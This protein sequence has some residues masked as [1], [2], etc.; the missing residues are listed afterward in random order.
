MNDQSTRPAVVS[1]ATDAGHRHWQRIQPSIERRPLAWAGGALLVLVVLFMVFRSPAQPQQGRGAGGRFGGGG[2]QPVATA[3]VENGDIPIIQN[4][5]GTVTPLAMVTVRSQIAGVLTQ[6]A[7]QE[8]QFVHQGDLL[9]LVDPRPYQHALEQA[10]GQLERDQALLKNAQLDATRYKVLFEQDSIAKQQLDTQNAL[11]LQYKGTV[12]TDQGQVNNAKLNLNYCYIKAPISGRVGLRQVD[13]GNYVAVGDT[14]GIAVITQMQPMTAIFTLPEDSVR[15]VLQRLRQG[16]TLTVTAYDRGVKNKLAEGVVTTID[17]QI[18][19]TTG[20]VKLRAQFP[21]LDESL[22]PNQFVNISLLVD[23]VKNT[24]VIPSAAIQRGAPGTFV[25]VV[26]QVDEAAAERARQ[27]QS[28]WRHLLYKVMTMFKSSDGQGGGQG[29]RQGRGGGHGGWAGGGADGAGPTVSIRPIKLGPS[30][31][32]RVAV[33]EGV[34]AG[35]MIVTDGADRLKDGAKI[36]L[37]ND[38]KDDGKGEATKG[39]AESG[40]KI[41]DDGQKAPDGAAS[42]HRS[43]WR[44]RE[45]GDQQYGEHPHRRRQSGDGEATPSAPPSGGSG[46][47]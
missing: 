11:V 24:T 8:G 28:W 41:G 15:P 31:G 40:E 1:R 45:T 16:N 39:G 20:T 42:D 22:F 26:N 27:N 46:P 29:R 14:N 33:Q 23:T 13:P 10:Q 21:N 35:E 32:E 4:A 7:F 5:L 19:T 9:A 44:D 30:A 47:Q 38:K 37:T 36:I 18:D 43:R 2:P 3:T 34:K 17:N 6:V 25:Y 12:Q